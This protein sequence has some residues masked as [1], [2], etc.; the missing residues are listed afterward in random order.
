MT[1]NF[2]YQ[3]YIFGYNASVT[4]F[5]PLGQITLGI[6]YNLAYLILGDSK[7]LNVAKVGSMIGAFGNYSKFFN[8]R[9]YYTMGFKSYFPATSSTESPEYKLKGWSETYIGLGYYFPEVKT[10]AR[11]LIGL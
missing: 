11:K 1:Y 5:S 2:D 9:V 4:G 8:E 6:G 7:E 10:F 3:A